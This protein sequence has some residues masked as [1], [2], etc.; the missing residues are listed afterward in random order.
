MILRQDGG[1][2]SLAPP[3]FKSPLEKFN[4]A[5]FVP[6]ILGEPRQQIEHTGAVAD[7]EEL[8]AI[9][10]QL[11]HQTVCLFLSTTRWSGLRISRIRIE[12]VA[13]AVAG[14]RLIL[15]RGIG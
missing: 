14:V 3:L 6:R 15:S 13:H 1:V 10:R 8:A 7:V 9:R 11:T 12:G 4:G 2:P 5:V